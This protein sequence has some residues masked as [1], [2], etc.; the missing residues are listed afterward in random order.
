MSLSISSSQLQI[1]PARQQVSQPNIEF[2]AITEESVVPINIPTI[3]HHCWP[4]SSG[5]IRATDPNA[6]STELKIAQRPLLPAFRAIRC[7]ESSFHALYK[8][9]RLAVTSGNIGGDESNGIGFPPV[10][11]AVTVN[12]S[13]HRNGSSVSKCI[14]RRMCGPTAVNGG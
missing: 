12:T 6:E 13:S 5:A 2:A 10:Q 4:H 7:Y 3:G 9:E 8:N 11:L 14:D 1:L